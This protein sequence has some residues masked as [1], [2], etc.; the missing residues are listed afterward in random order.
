MFFFFNYYVQSVLRGTGLTFRTTS[1][2]HANISGAFFRTLND[3]LT[4]LR[5]SQQSRDSS[6]DGAQEGPNTGE[7]GA[8]TG[9]GGAGN[10]LQKPR[11]VKRGSLH[12]PNPTDHD[13][14]YDDHHQHE[15]GLLQHRM[16]S[17]HQMTSDK[18]L[19]RSGGGGERSGSAERTR[20]WSQRRKSR[21]SEGSFN[22]RSSINNDFDESSSVTTP[23]NRR[24]DHIPSNPLSATFRVGFSIQNLTGQP[25]RYLQQWEGGRRTVQ[26]INNNERGLLNFVASKTLIRNNQVIEETFDVQMELSGANVGSRNRRKAVGNRVALQVSGYRW[27]HAVQAD[28]LGV[29]YEELYSV[30][31]RVHASQVFKN[32]KIVNSLKLM[33]EVMPYCGGRMLRLRSVFTIKNNTRHRLKILAKEGTSSLGTVGGET[34]QQ[35][36]GDEQDAPFLLESGENFYVPLALLRR[37]VL[38]SKG[39]SLGYLYLCPADIG[40][41]EE[42]LVSRPNSQPDS[43]EY[44]TDPINLY[45]TVVKSN[46]AAEREEQEARRISHDSDLDYAYYKDRAYDKDNFTQ[47]VCHI[48]PKLKSRYGHGRKSGAESAEWQN[49]T[50]YQRQQEQRRTAARAALNKLPPF[51]YCVEVHSGTDFASSQKIATQNSSL[52]SRFFSNVMHHT[53]SQVNSPVNFTISKF[54]FVFFFSFFLFFSILFYTCTVSTADGV[55]HISALFSTLSPTLSFLHFIFI[56]Y[57]LIQ[58]IIFICSNPP[59]HRAGEPAPLQRHLRTSTRHPE[60]RL[61]ELLYR[62]RH[63]QTRA[64]CNPG[65]AAAASNQPQVL[66]QLRGCVDSPAAPLGILRGHCR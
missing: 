49:N 28:E 36:K 65:G 2:V 32:W 38:A 4:T 39:K 7:A 58:F 35:Q 25:V 53:A 44:T 9:A 30:L 15:L 46:E 22:R 42:E 64:H 56:F 14:Q 33:V 48:N 8:A 27:L 12:D 47:L 31:G 6:E 61:V 10:A 11:K 19:S 16:P 5:T 45:Q 1:A 37:S 3:I 43:V 40:A 52:S 29:H 57:F 21:V 23:V 55:F 17:I 13:Y 26:Y 60:A 34:K 20:S 50:D 66:P 24:L 18:R 41:I 59:A 54:L 63:C 51:C 62:R